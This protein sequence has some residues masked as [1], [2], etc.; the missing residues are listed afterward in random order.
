[1][2]KVLFV[3]RANIC[4]S[5]IAHGVFAK[6][7]ELASLDHAVKVDSAGTHVP[8]PGRLPDK[9]ARKTAEKNGYDLGSLRARQLTRDLLSQNQYLIVMDDQNLRDAS[10]IATEEDKKKL[11]LLLSFT[12][13]EDQ[14]LP[15]PYFS[16]SAGMGFV[17][18]P[19]GSGERAFVVTLDRI[20]IACSA[21]LETLQRRHNL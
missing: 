6:Q 3:C 18:D 13:A 21:L 17:P 14:Q 5:A 10:E 16:G 20:E 19:V 7:L 8:Y 9:R 1:M 12:G 2:I 4:R 11:S 15:D